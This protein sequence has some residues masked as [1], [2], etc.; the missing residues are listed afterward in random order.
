M[1]NPFATPWTVVHQTPPSVGFPRQEYWSELPFPSPE[2]DLSEPGIEPESSALTSRFLTAEPQEKR[3]TLTYSMSKRKASSTSILGEGKQ[4][5]HIY[6]K[7][8]INL[9]QKQ[10]LDYSFSLLGLQYIP[11]WLIQNNFG[12]FLGKRNS[13]LASLCS[14]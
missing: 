12:G 4:V 7:A 10:L 14:L 5:L 13:W 2:D 1:S 11:C 8:F 6:Q 3:C 9:W